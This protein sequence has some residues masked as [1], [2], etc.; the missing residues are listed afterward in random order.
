L[1]GTT[2][3][4]NNITA[5]TGTFTNLFTTSTLWSNFTT[6]T[7]FKNTSG[8]AG[9]VNCTGNF[10]VFGKLM[11]LYG[12]L[13][14]WGS[15]NIGG[16]PALVRI[17]TGFEIDTDVCPSINGQQYGWGPGFFT[18][19]LSN[20][21]GNHFKYSIIGNGI[22]SSSF[23]TS[24]TVVFPNCTG[25]LGT[26]LPLVYDKDNIT[27][28]IT[29]TK[30]NDLT[31]SKFGDNIPS[32]STPYWRSI[33]YYNNYLALDQI[34]IYGTFSSL[35]NNKITDASYEG[36]V[37]NPLMSSHYYSIGIGSERY[38]VSFFCVLPIK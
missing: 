31:Q 19:V 23:Q 5:T 10:Y 1:S 18:G 35:E 26:A 25:L 37:V 15:G 33:D 27:F 16:N 4:Y 9:T 6:T 3:T 17:P 21:S 38:N 8:S 2:L 22:V 7:T 29:R 14:G 24:A 34:G 36:L 20:T 12:T 11:Y 30:F 32:T 13:L 28:L